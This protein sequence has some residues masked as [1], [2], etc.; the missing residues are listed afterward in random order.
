MPYNMPQVDKISF[1]DDMMDVES[2]QSDLRSKNLAQQA[3]QLENAVN[4]HKAIEGALGGIL[5]A[6]AESRPN[7]YARTR[8]MLVAQGIIRPEDAPEQYDEGMILQYKQQLDQ[9]TPAV[10]QIANALGE[11][12]ASGNMQSLNDILTAGKMMP[13]GAEYGQGGVLAPIEGYVPFVSQ[14]AEAKAGGTETGKGYAKGALALPKQEATMS[15]L[16]QKDQIVKDKV[17]TALGQSGQNF[18]G[19]PT[20]TGLVGQLSSGIGGS[21][22]K[23][24]DSTLA[25]IKANLGFQELQDMRNNSPTGGA[26]GQVS[27]FENRQLQSLSSNL[28]QSQSQEQLQQNLQEIVTFI[29]GR[30]ERM[31]RAYETD[32]QRFG[33]KAMQ[34]VSK[35]FEQQDD[36][37]MPPPNEIM[38]HAPTGQVPTATSSDMPANQAQMQNAVQQ[39]MGQQ[40]QQDEVVDYMHYFGGGK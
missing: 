22:A 23:D 35:Y 2:H 5:Q 9:H 34:G 33:A 1:A 3:Q 12:R 19:I 25:T 26:L 11:A 27:D 8:N 30:Q 24:L 32:K 20:T 17:K 38:A 21:P 40:P 16:A 15:A 7:L 39:V 37:V 36:G 28:D 29:E 10:L 31:R 14:E 18:Y 13:K 4:Q 6:P